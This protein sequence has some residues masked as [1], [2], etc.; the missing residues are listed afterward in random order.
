MERY[1]LKG[2]ESEIK[3]QKQYT[4]LMWCKLRFILRIICNSKRKSQNCKTL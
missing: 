1:K 2:G 4:E 3:W